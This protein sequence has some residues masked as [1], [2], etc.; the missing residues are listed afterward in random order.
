MGGAVARAWVFPNALPINDL[1]AC[2]GRCRAGGEQAVTGVRY[3][4]RAGPDG[5]A[6]ESHGRD[7]NR[8]TARSGM[9]GAE[10]RGHVPTEGPSRSLDRGPVFVMGGG[11]MMGSMRR[12][13]RRG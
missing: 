6:D 9:I 4:V 11:N 3:R 8:H 10:S 7:F 2:T 1:L 12:V 13:P 5:V